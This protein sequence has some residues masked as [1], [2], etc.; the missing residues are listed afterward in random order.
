MKNK[1]KIIVAVIFAVVII[2]LG[3]SYMTSN[4]K[5]NTVETQVTSSNIYQIEQSNAKQIIDTCKNV[6]HCSVTG[7]DNL[8]KTADKQ[9]VLGTFS[10]LVSMY[11]TSV[12]P[13]HETAHHL[14][15]WLYGYTGSLNESLSYAKQECG[16]SIFHGVLQGYF[17]TEHFHNVDASQIDIT[18]LCAQDPQNPYSITRWQCLHG[19]G[20]GLAEFYDYNITKAVN[21]CDE[22]KP[23]WE[24]TSCAKGLFMQNVVHYA[25]TGSGDFNKND[26]FYP[27][28][29]VSVKYA[30]AC[31]HYN[32]SYMWVQNNFDINATFD[33]C[34][35]ITPSSLVSSCYH[36]FGR[37]LESI[38][39]T[40]V[41]KAIDSCTL[42]KES[43]Y[44][45]DCLKGMV[46]TIVNRDANLDNGFKF[47]SILKDDFKAGCYESMGQWV[48]MMY[49]DP[50]ERKIECSNAESLDYIA[51]CMHA[52]LDDVNLL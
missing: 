14:G 21:R 32:V 42:G 30:P 26:I 23:G 28:D 6:M 45:V 40:S 1:S 20:H 31:Y 47:C 5:T 46:M 37:Q 8:T 12:Y 27:C 25:E 18:K 22:F 10:D 50:Q 7:L 17:M 4:Q 43:Q 51:D 35:K 39:A 19:I 36:G 15:M 34:D 52:S 49:N 2:G 3:A 29:S 48:D 11:D 38:A 44:H 13:C 16:G 9:V 41:T 33:E 24:Q